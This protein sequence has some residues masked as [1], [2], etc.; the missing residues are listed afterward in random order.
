MYQL[1]INRQ[2]LEKRPLYIA[3]FHSC[4][5]SNPFQ[6]A[7]IPVNPIAMTAMH[8]YPGKNRNYFELDKKWELNPAKRLFSGY[9]AYHATYGKTQATR[10]HV[11]KGHKTNAL[12]IQ[13]PW[14]QLQR[15]VWCSTTRWGGLYTGSHNVYHGA[16]WRSYFLIYRQKSYSK[17]RPN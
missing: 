12:N 13:L 16:E 11:T 1:L 8:K 14:N 3:H 6:S 7:F 9:C 4:K 5:H 2:M 10:I 17:F 15:N